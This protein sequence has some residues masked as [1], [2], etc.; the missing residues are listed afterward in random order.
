MSSENPFTLATA[1]TILSV[2]TLNR[3]VRSFSKYRN[4]DDAEINGA[5]LKDRMNTIFGLSYSVQNLLMNIS[6]DEETS[7]LAVMILS[8]QINDELDALHDDILHLPADIIT[9]VIPLL[10]TQRR[11]WK[12]CNNAEFYHDNLGSAHDNDVF[13]GLKEL[14][15]RVYLL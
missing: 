4:Q 7:Q 3:L 15:K 13:S 1:A 9:P 12:N 6:D 14:K 2:N 5:D 8:R 11:F 10:D